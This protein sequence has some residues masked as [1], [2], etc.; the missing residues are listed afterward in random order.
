MQELI[1]HSFLW[2][3]ENS[4]LQFNLSLVF[5][6]AWVKAEIKT[7]GSEQKF[8]SALKW[9]C[10]LAACPVAWPTSLCPHGLSRH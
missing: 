10:H 5:L 2:L 6:A 3:S 4:S 7:A 8:S 9:G 1:K